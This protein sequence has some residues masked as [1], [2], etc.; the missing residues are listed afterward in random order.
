[1]RLE[2][3]GNLIVLFAAVFAVMEKGKIESGIVG[4]SISYA[5]QVGSIASVYNP[6]YSTL[7]VFFQITSIMNWMVRTASE[8]ETNIVSV[9]RVEEYAEVKQEVC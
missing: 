4:L 8:V 2:I 6:R 5:M 7:Q 1:M 9:E 3:V